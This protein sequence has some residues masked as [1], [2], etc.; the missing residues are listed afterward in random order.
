MP[1]IMKHRKAALTVILTVQLML[2]MDFLIVVVSL[3][4]IQADLG[5]T[6]AGLSWVPNAFALAFGGLLLLGGRLGDM[7]GQVKAFQI[8]IAIFVIASL[9]GGI[10]PSPLVLILVRVSQGIGSA[11]AAPSVLALISILAR[12]QREKNRGLSLFIAVSSMGAS[13][14][15]ILG[16]ALTEFISWRW[17]LLINIPIGIIALTAIALLVPETDKVKG[18]IDYFGALTATLG[19]TALVFGFI[20][21]ADNDW[22][23]IITISSFISAVVL[24][25]LFFRIES[26]IAQPLLRLSIF[27]LRSHKGGLFIMALIVGMHFAAL[28]LMLQYFQQVLGLSPLMAGIAYLPLTATVFIVTQF[29]PWLITKFGLRTLLVTGSILVAVSLIGFSQLDGDSGYLE[30]V[31]RPLLLHSVGIALVFTPGSIVIMEAVANKDTGIASGVLQMDQQIGGAVGIAAIVTI[32]TAYS[33]PG[34]FY[35]GF[36]SAFIFAAM[37]CA[38]AALISIFTIPGKNKLK[39]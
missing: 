18:K 26:R 14:G 7:I 23:S 16:G 31:L 24:L 37:I 9:A 13:V 28:F 35:S 12:D 22:S 5:F 25:G 11:L 19:C 21:A 39:S 15:L 33:Q 8:G 3:K 6:A 20:S 32:S 1:I 27:N 10:A 2:Q 36:G 29:V 17:S 4:H 30:N 38:I 34:V